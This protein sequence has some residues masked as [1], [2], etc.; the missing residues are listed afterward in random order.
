MNEQGHFE[1]PT[2][3]TLPEHYRDRIKEL[4]PERMWFGFFHYLE[5]GILPGGFLTAVLENDFMGAVNRADDENIKLLQN[6][7]IVLY[8][9]LPEAAWGSKEKVRAWAK[10]RRKEHEAS[11]TPRPDPA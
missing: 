2:R 3:F 5:D 1:D 6:Y 9:Y 7:I 10:A 4:I 11:K 8:S